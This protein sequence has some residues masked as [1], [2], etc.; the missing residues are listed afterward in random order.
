LNNFGKL[1]GWSTGWD[2]APIIHELGMLEM[3]DVSLVGD[4]GNV[5][6]KQE[7]S[8]AEP[9]D[10][11]LAGINSKLLRTAAD[12]STD[13]YRLYE[14]LTDKALRH[15]TVAGLEQSIQG[16]M[17]DMA[18]LKYNLEDYRAAT[19][20]FCL[21]TPFFGESGWS[22]LELSMLVMYT[23]CLKHL[24][25]KEFVRVALKLL[26]KAC[27]VQNARQKFSTLASNISAG[28]VRAGISAA[29][30]DAVGSV[31]DLA[32]ALPGDA[33]VPLDSFVTNVTLDSTPMYSDDKDCATMSMRLQSLLPGEAT[34]DMVALQLVAAD[35]AHTEVV[36]RA[37]ERTL[38]V[39][40]TNV[41]TL[42]CKVSL[43]NRYRAD[44]G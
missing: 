43:H 31:S 11:S 38:L 18:V 34:F 4:N 10:L 2:E 5:P 16:A 42:H 1:R 6:V 27:A 23:N 24:K 7:E 36:F 14:I 40:G 8:N 37:A 26:T 19:S 15:F 25:S 33:R 20:F 41:V 44:G 28:D 21:T 3:V 39:P 32:L 17:S 9:R 35:V 13:F 22:W 29:V 12:N 30:R